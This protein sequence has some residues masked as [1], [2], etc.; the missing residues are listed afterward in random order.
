M[1]HDVWCHFKK[2]FS[3][4]MAVNLFGNDNENQS[5]LQVEKIASLAIAR[6]FD[7]QRRTFMRWMMLPTVGMASQLFAQTPAPAIRTVPGLALALG[8]GAA[9]GFTHI[10]VIEVLEGLGI[11]PE[12]VV[13]TSAGSLVGALYASGMSIPELKKQALALDEADLGDWTI[14]GRGPLKGEAIERLVNRLIANKPMESFPI[15]FAAVATDLFNGKP[16]YFTRGNAGQAVRASSSV[17][18]VFEPVSIRGRDYVDGGLVSP[19]PV[20]AARALGAKKVIA[21]DISAKP[22]FQSTDSMPQMF[23][24]TFA[25]M[26]QQMGATELAGADV[27]IVPEVG[28]LSAGD[29]SQRLRSIQEG[30]RS[31]QLQIEAIKRLIAAR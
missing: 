10:G 27:A 7:S 6:N 31:A 18:G 29:F 25:I 8:G 19:I 16:I 9:R 15:K 26:G 4:L 23:L 20:S 12:W 13:G 5:H 17:P 30:N 21:V 1:F 22:K 14:T 24:Q 3:R 28:D 2:E 11:R